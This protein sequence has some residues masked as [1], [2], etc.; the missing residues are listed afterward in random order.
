VNPMMRAATEA[1]TAAFPLFTLAV[2]ALHTKVLSVHVGD[3]V[4]PAIALGLIASATVFT[5]VIMVVHVRLS[6]KSPVMGAAR[7]AVIAVVAVVVV[8]S[9]HACLTFGSAGLVH[10]LL[11]QVFYACLVGGGPAAIGGALFARSIESRVFMGR[12]NSIRKRN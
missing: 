6:R 5:T 3:A 8:A 2:F 12:G 11:G 10:S 4:A 9:A 7:G 1:A